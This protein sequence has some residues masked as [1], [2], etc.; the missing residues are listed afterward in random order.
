MHGIN[1]SKIPNNTASWVK[2]SKLLPRWSR[3][4]ITSLA[5]SYCM[6]V[7]WWWTL[8]IGEANGFKWHFQD[9]EG[10]TNLFNIF[11]WIQ[12]QLII[13]TWRSHIRS[14][15][16]PKFSN[17]ITLLLLKGWVTVA[18][19]VIVYQKPYVGYYI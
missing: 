5:G 3:I 6:V 18:V 19:W 11:C 9:F 17:H 15:I 4:H 7:L 14:H 13:L 10:F 12:K 16:H 8:Q 1:T 2:T